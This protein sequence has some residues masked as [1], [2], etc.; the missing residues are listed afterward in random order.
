MEPKSRLITSKSEKI[1]NPNNASFLSPLGVMEQSQFPPNQ[2]NQFRFWS[3]MIIAFSDYFLSHQLNLSNIRLPII[4]LPKPQL[5]LS[6]IPRK[7]V[8]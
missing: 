1:E 7:S 4:H 8:V 5:T 3:W 6:N 2:I